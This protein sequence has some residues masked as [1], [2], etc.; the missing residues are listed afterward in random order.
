MSVWHG[1]TGRNLTNRTLKCAGR[2]KTFFI[3]VIC[4]EIVQN[5]EQNGSLLIQLIHD[6]NV[7]PGAIELL[8]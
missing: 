5:L 7:E 3:F 2:I 8:C 1:K 6:I 4:F